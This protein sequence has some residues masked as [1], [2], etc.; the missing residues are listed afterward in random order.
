M[1][2]LAL[3]S[4]EQVLFPAPYVEDEVVPL[5]I[6][7]QRV[8]QMGEK[9]PVELEAGKIT[10]LG[11]HSNRPFIFLGL[12]FLFLGLPLLGFGGY[13]WLS[14]RGYPGF[15]EKP[16]DANVA[17]EL[18]D[19]D[20]TRLQAIA[21]GVGGLLLGAIGLLCAKRQRH[22][23]MC[24]AGKRVLKLKVKDKNAQT[25]VLM[26]VQAIVNTFKAQEKQAAATPPSGAPPPAPAKT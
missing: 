16:P 6:T 17:S 9:G 23:V 12:F 15:K 14:V 21:C 3:R 5:I 11:R 25:Q 8:V 13:L 18:V 26:T 1:G 2:I 7:S 22:A 19:P 20:T 10:F 24:R 4:Q